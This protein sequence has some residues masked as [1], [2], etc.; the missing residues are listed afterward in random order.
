MSFKVIKGVKAVK[1]FK[2]HKQIQLLVMVDKA[3]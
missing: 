3:L 2:A 1:G